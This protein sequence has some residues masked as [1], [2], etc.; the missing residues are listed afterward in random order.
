[1]GLQLTTVQ[2]QI[3]FGC[4]EDS[5]SLVRR[6]FIFAVLGIGALAVLGSLSAL[7]FLFLRD[8]LGDGLS[9]ETIRDARPAIDAIVPAAIFLPYFWFVYRRDRQAEAEVTAP[10]EPR[11]MKTVAVLSSEEGAPFLRG[12]EAAL[13]YEVRTL[14]WADPGAEALPQLPLEQYEELARRIGDASGASV[15]LIPTGL[16]CASCRT[17]S[18]VN[19]SSI[20]IL[21]RS[22][23]RPR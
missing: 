20:I 23:I 11:I 5:S 10:S 17:T 16:K 18:W 12:L 2:R 21:S 8:V 19:R 3:S 4:T 14:A 6:I 7:I 1:M 15:L 9:R 22:R 13:G